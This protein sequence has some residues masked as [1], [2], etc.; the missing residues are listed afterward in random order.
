[1]EQVTN[2]KP[3][4]VVV[5]RNYCN[6]LTLS[7]AL[8]MAG[9]EIEVLRIYKKKLN[10]L[11]LMNRLKPDSF[12]KYVNSFYEYIVNDDYDSMIEYLNGMTNSNQKKLLFPVDDYSTFIIDNY[13]DEL[14]LNYIIPSIQNKKGK[15]NHLMNKFEQKKLAAEQGLPILH[16]C[17]VDIKNGEFKLPENIPY[18]CFIKPNISMKS[19][20]A[21]M[22]KCNNEQELKQVLT[23]I[24]KNQ[25]VQILVEEYANIKNEYSLLGL[26]TEEKIITPGVFRVVHGGHKERKGI[27]VVGEIEDASKFK[28]IIKE[29]EKYIH[30]LHYTGLFDVDLLESEDG[31][32]YFVELNFRSGASIDAITKMGINLPALL[33]DYL[34]FGTCIKDCEIKECG[35]RFVSEKILLEEFLRSDIEYETLK[36]YLLNC[37]IHFIYNEND[38]EPYIHFKKFYYISLFMKIPFR[39]KDYIKKIS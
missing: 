19:T 12:S 18:P 15:I 32:I 39:I 33:A 29:C 36:E 30:S 6:I 2:N 37:D 21:I 22:C 28:M 38:I 24:G 14:S 27:T 8:G 31:K 25:D 13:L 10:P 3:G 20:K 35:Q 16:Y 23:N 1:M 5:G 17:L 7:R 9:Y 34:A 11:N 26:S 4:V